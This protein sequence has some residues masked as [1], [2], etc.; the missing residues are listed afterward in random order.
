MANAVMAG[1]HDI[2]P[3]DEEDTADPISYKKLLKLEGMWALTKDILGFTFDGDNKTLWLES[4]KRDALLTTMK[5]WIR[6]ANRTK[7][8]IPFDEFRS[9]IA[10]LRHA[11]ISIPSGKGLLSPCNAI[12]RMQPPIVYLHSKNRLLRQ[13]I[14]DCRTLLR[15][16]TVAPTK[17]S[18]LVAA[19]PRGPTS[20][21]SRMHQDMVL[22][23]SLLART[24]NAYQQYSDTS[25]P[26]I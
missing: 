7:G 11:F 14:C 10:K 13:A 4:P 15:E 21:E 23:E 1:V 12:L 22:G 2:F 8:G 19:W 6:A 16:S 3:A 24:S 18:E 17:C 9:I 5:Q 25:G 20:S 26:T